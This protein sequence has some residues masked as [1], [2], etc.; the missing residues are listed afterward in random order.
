MGR[1][2]IISIII[3]NNN[4]LDKKLLF[5]YKQ[6][7]EYIHA[8]TI[9]IHLHK[10]LFFFFINGCFFVSAGAYR[11]NAQIQNVNKIIL[12]YVGIITY[13]A[14]YGITRNI[15]NDDT[16]HIQ[17]LVACNP[18]ANARN[19]LYNIKI[20]IISL[21][22]PNINATENIIIALVIVIYIPSSPYLI[23]ASLSSS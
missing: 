12:I 4:A 11:K 18:Y 14:R 10:I 6:K 19:T 20:I 21:N 5:T 17:L 9:T 1:I 3:E 15:V 23:S 16:K 7:N 22:I 2:N 8:I 13:I